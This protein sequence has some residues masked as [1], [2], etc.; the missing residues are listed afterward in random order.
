KGQPRVDFEVELV[1]ANAG[2]TNIINM[3]DTYDRPADTS[4]EGTYARSGAYV[5]K[6]ENKP[7]HRIP[8][9]GVSAEA[10]VGRAR[11][12]FSVFE[13]EAKG[14]NASA[15]AEASVAIFGAEA[16]A[17]AEIGSVSATAGPVDVK[18]GLGLDTGASIGLNGLEVKFLGTGFSVGPKP[19]LSFLGS[20]V[21]KTQ[22]Y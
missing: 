9:A 4:T 1:S 18:L 22:L 20:K 10:G 17:R 16:M 19:S 8:R 13:A 21:Y 12:E 5:I 3:V 2:L 11:A 7:M 15:S 6:P 14:P